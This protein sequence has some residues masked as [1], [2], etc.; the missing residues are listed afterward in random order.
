MR[1]VVAACAVLIALGGGVYAW[2]VGAFA[3]CEPLGT[4]L[5]SGL[6]RSIAE[7][8][9]RSI[10][11]L[12][13]LPDG[14]LLVITRQSGTD[15]SEPQFIV[16][17]AS[18]EG[19]VVSETALHPIDPKATWTRAA[20]SRDGSLIAASILHEPTRVFDR[21]G[22]LLATLDIYQ[23]AFLGFDRDGLLLAERG[24]YPEG[25][26]QWDAVVAFDLSK[27]KQR[28]VGASS[29]E[30]RAIFAHGVQTALSTDGATFAQALKGGRDSGIVGARVGAREHPS[31]PGV[32]LA[33]RLA[34]GC[35]YSLPS[36]AFSPDA[37]RLAATFSC[38][39]RWGATTSALIVWELD[40]AKLLATIPTNWDWGEMLWLD[41]QS[42]VVERYNA[43]ARRGELR[44]VELAR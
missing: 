10:Q 42:L 6:C 41:D 18:E 31:R 11:A 23:P 28:P 22:H 19:V 33:A 36:F 27:P 14:N 29:A 32:L 25:L 2:G 37:S 3:P 21:R 26:P 17:I 35:S 8:N 20:V 38:P 43:D 5:A 13:R 30:A 7:F 9:G 40:Q 39:P 12:G 15:P 1:L 4:F 24:H 34:T 16:E 44:L